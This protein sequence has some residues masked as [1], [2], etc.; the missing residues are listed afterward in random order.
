MKILALEHDVAGASESNSASLLRA[1][2][3]RVWELQQSGVLREI[4]FRD[5]GSQAV[6]IL[7]TDGVS[8]AEAILAQLPLVQA[9]RARFEVIGLRPYT[10]FSRL[11]AT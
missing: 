2:A 1:E 6:L 8:H 11:F 10:G 5:R 7:E 3:R 9:G 4:Y